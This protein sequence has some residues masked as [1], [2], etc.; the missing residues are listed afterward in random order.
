MAIFQAF[1]AAGIGFNMSSTSSS[2]WSFVGSNP[3]ITVDLIHDDG[4]FAD[5]D[6]YGS[7]LIDY[8]SATYQDEGDGITLDDLTYENDGEVVLTI[9]NLNL[10]TSID[11]LQANAWYVRINAGADTF[12]GNDYDDVIRA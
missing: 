2:G 7:D 3:D 10:Y 8:F 9:K 6:V 4:S 12:Y 1:N 11:D 5:Y